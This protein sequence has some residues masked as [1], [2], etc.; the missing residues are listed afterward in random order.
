MFSRA[1]SVEAIPEAEGTGDNHHTYLTEQ[2]NSS[3]TSAK[4]FRPETSPQS[5]AKYLVTRGVRKHERVVKVYE[6]L[7]SLRSEEETL[8]KHRMER[9]A[10]VEQRTHA[11]LVMLA[12]QRKQA[13]QKA[14]QKHQRAELKRVTKETETKQQIA[15]REEHLKRRMETV[16]KLKDAR[17]HDYMSSSFLEFISQDSLFS[18]T[19]ELLLRSEEDAVMTGLNSVKGRLELGE[20]KWKDQLT[21]KSMSAKEHLQKVETIKETTRVATIEEEEANLRK[22][23]EKMKLLQAKISKRV[24]SASAKSKTIGEYHKVKE[25]KHS[26][27]LDAL[28]KEITQRENVL[29]MK[30]QKRSRSIE[31]SKEAVAA[32]RDKLVNKSARKSR[33]Q[34]AN[35][36]KQKAEEMRKKLLI[37]RKEQD[38]AQVA[39]MLSKTKDE[40]SRFSVERCHLLNKMR[41]RLRSPVSPQ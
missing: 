10:Q 12:E 31:R 32:Y 28:R 9:I 37:L 38:K 11:R 33:R 34:S 1:R 30:D 21:T 26:N 8:R 23:I 18:N 19:Q 39:Q 5:F 40:I 13:A 36:T 20:S 6:N 25:T 35:Y 17:N 2:L 15:L 3:Q 16:Q 27:A 22:S 4:S 41:S 14:L 24:R 29:E 7:I